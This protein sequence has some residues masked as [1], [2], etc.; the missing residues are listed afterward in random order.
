MKLGMMHPPATFFSGH[1]VSYPPTSR[2]SFH[3]MAAG[4]CAQVAKLVKSA[5]AGPAASG[6]AGLQRSV[7]RC[8]GR[9]PQL[10]GGDVVDLT[11][12]LARLRWRDEATWKDIGSAV[13]QKVEQMKVAELVKV[14]GSFSVASQPNPEMLKVVVGR[15]KADPSSLHSWSWANFILSLQ[16]AAVKPDK[17]L[18]K[19]AA[20]AILKD[21]DS[22]KR[23]KTPYIMGFVDAS[24]CAGFFHDAMFRLLSVIMVEHME[25]LSPYELTK[26][27]LTW[28]R[29][30]C[31]DD[32]LLK[33]LCQAIHHNLPSIPKNRISYTIHSLS[34]L[35][36]KDERLLVDLASAWATTGPDESIQVLHVIF[37]LARLRALDPVLCDRIAACSLQ[38]V[39]NFDAR[40]I[41]TI[42][43]ACSQSG[44]THVEFLES[45]G[46]AARR[47]A[48]EFSA[49]E[50]CNVSCAGATLSLV[51]ILGSCIPAAVVERVSEFDGFA[52]L[53][54]MHA[55]TRLSNNPGNY[56]PVLELAAL[57]LVPTLRPIDLRYI[58]MAWAEA[59][60]FDSKLMDAVAS[61]AIQL[62]DSLDPSTVNHMV[63]A[64]SKL[65]IADVHLFK[66]LGLQCAS[67][68]SSFPT[69]ELGH[70]S[71][72]FVN[73][74]IH[75]ELP[76]TSI[77]SEALNRVA[78]MHSVPGARLAR[79]FIQADLESPEAIEFLESLASIARENG[80][81][82][83]SPSGLEQTDFQKQCTETVQDF[84]PSWWTNV[85]RWVHCSAWCC[86]TAMDPTWTW[87]WI[88]WTYS[89]P[90][91]TGR[92]ALGAISSWRTWVCRCW[93]WRS[94]TR[95]IW[96]TTCCRSLDIPRHLAWM[97]FLQSHQH[98]RWG[99]WM[100]RRWRC[101]DMC[102]MRWNL[103]E[104]SM[105][106]C[107]KG[108]Y[109]LKI[110][111]KDSRDIQRPFEQLAGNGTC[112]SF[113]NQ[114]STC[115]SCLIGFLDHLYSNFSVS[116][117]SGWSL[118]P[119]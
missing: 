19:A 17:Q 16:R 87:S 48:A 102:G 58:A 47:K 61:R 8:L 103:E 93:D 100:R 85:T 91:W 89:F 23:L 2:A 6:H 82:R 3:L 34:L 51:P 64:L 5:A 53:V 111:K 114:P 94:G 36:C 62:I 13:T 79:A 109:F 29:A 33:S 15:L 92:C 75:H 81:T 28:G 11:R 65:R 71:L 44:C 106:A 46:E 37:G 77:A 38:F 98:R 80:W 86:R 39:P 99:L 1:F 78:K 73:A 10:Q 115:F 74:G 26:V 20:D 40:A 50:L 59:D 118:D 70:I 32:V 116:V 104:C 113:A 43:W 67:T 97:T 108:F 119:Y 18:L 24:F 31:K 95:M 57:P 21:K 4:R 101:V 52:L 27:A 66:A 42:L 55:V 41:A 63:R 69:R 112:L 110:Y 60:T 88:P 9:L 12:S 72:A 107:C 25:R 83:L 35:D 84:H 14:A 7:Q 105:K 45:L 56:L 96:G 22:L 30:T 76:L 117:K 49:A 54:T 68:V 90:G